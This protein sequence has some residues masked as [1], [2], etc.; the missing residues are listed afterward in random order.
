MEGG[1]KNKMK[2]LKQ[3]LNIAA[4]VGAILSAAQ[5]FGTALVLNEYIDNPEVVNYAKYSILTSMGQMALCGGYFFGP[6][7][8][9]SIRNSFN[10]DRCRTFS[11]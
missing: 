2:N 3:K 5:I 6:G 11:P 4:N 9:D 7:I 10:R 8:V 1:L